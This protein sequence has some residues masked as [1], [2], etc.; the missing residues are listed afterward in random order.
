MLVQRGWELWGSREG[1]ST[2]RTPRKPPFTSWLWGD[3]VCLR[4]QPNLPQQQLPTLPAANRSQLCAGEV[5][6][7]STM[8]AAKRVLWWDLGTFLLGN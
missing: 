2:A 7:G 5:G 3:A 8:A 4:P 1:L 6:P